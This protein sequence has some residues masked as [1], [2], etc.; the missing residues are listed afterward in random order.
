MKEVIEKISKNYDSFYLY[1]E[2]GIHK[3]IENLIKNFPGVDFL[4]SVKCNPNRQVLKSIFSK[5]IG[6]DAASLNEV[7]LAKEC[8]LCKDQIYYS[9]PGKTIKDLKIAMGNA[10][11]IADS[12]SE[13]EKINSIA[14][15]R[16]TIEKIGVRINPNFG[17]YQ[18]EKTPSKFGID[19]DE[20]LNFLNETLSNIKIVGIHVHLHSQEL[21]IE[22]LENYYKQVI[23][24]AR[25]IKAQIGSIEFL[26]M[27]SGIGINYSQQD[28]AIDIE[29]LG[30]ITEQIV[31]EFKNENAKTKIF[32]ETGRYLVGKSGYY[33]TKVLD[34]KKS[35]GQ[36]Y[37]IL[38]NTLNGFIRPSIERM[39]LEKN[40][41]S[42]SSEPLFTGKNSF[43]FSTLKEDS[44]EVVNLV[45]NLCTATDVIAENIELPILEE[46]DLI[47]INNA[48]SYAAV[49]SPMQFSSQEK[50][51]EIFLRK[52]GEII[53]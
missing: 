26:N 28:E 30:V 29:T 18:K 33:I 10:T 31:Q 48:G 5:G 32:I 14:K 9:A 7:L 34:K 22:V 17:F 44:T 45:G 43:S 41:N 20:F 4:Y 50:P 16:K 11:I 38:K 25:R 40:P 23:S 49:L 13:I 46:G 47:I 3:S 39:V 6:A 52:N 1:D 27:G 8:G 21:K 12:L 42:S 2:K 51:G 19:E 53:E 36:T 24:L 35:C 37:I 15:E